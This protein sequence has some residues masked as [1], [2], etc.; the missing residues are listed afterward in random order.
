M[1]CASV[2]VVRVCVAR[3]RARAFV[4]CVELVLCGV[5][6][7][8]LGLGHDTCYQ[9][10]LTL[11]LTTHHSIPTTQPETSPAHTPAHQILVHD[12]AMPNKI[13]PYLR[14]NASQR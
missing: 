8:V 3:V 7:M 2:C 13:E 4:S 6:C 1:W 14:W 12:L 11:T 10:T 5:L 9:L